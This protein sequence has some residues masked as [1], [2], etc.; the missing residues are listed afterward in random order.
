M[1]QMEFRKN[2]LAFTPLATMDAALT[3]EFTK[4]EISG[5]YQTVFLL[6][7]TIEALAAEIAERQKKI[8]KE[9]A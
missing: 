8:D 2:I 6:P 7:V 1:R 3:Q 4:G 5:M 9:E